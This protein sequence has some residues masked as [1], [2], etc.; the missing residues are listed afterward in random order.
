MAR[1]NDLFPSK[2]LKASD[3][4]PLKQR[5]QLPVQVRISH[6]AQENIGLDDAQKKLKPVVYFIGKDKGLV[7]NRTNADVLIEATGS[8]DTDA[9]QNL[10]IGLD[11]QKDKYKGAPVDCLRFVHVRQ[12]R[13]PQ[14]SAAVAAPATA[15]R[16]AYAQQPQRQQPAAPPPPANDW[17]SAEPPASLAGDW[18]NATPG[19][20]FD[21]DDPVP[22]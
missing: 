17:G 11:V 2:Y 20:A 13:Q 19:Q 4:M 9:W 15:T 8:D 7:L 22:F 5:G 12:Q 3:L 14:P 1:I 10:V 18:G 21:D 16:G 6:V